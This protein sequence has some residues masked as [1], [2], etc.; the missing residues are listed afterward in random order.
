MLLKKNIIKYKF[1]PLVLQTH[2][3]EITFLRK[4]LQKPKIYSIRQQKQIKATTQKFFCIRFLWI[5]I[6]TFFMF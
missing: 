1:T 5:K 4:D 3:Y 6:R 2:K